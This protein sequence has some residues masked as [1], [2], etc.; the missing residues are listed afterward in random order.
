MTLVLNIVSLHSVII[1]SLIHIHFKRSNIFL[2]LIYLNIQINL[3]LHRTYT[4]GGKQKLKKSD[5]EARGGA[6][7]IRI[8]DHYPLKILTFFSKLPPP[9]KENKLLHAL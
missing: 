4:N 2:L 5:F 7:E 3:I 6:G 9:A 1:G 8:R